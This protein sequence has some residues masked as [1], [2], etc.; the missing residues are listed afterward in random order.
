MC[1]IAGAIVYDQQQARLDSFVTAVNA[2]AS[3]GMDS[4]GVV[5]WSPASGIRRFAVLRRDDRDWLEELGRPAAG[6]PTIYLHTSRAE[7][8]TEW[9]QEKKDFDIPP[10][11]DKGIAVAHNGIIANDHTLALNYGLSRISAIDTAVLPPLIAKIGVWEA[12]AAIQGGAALAILDTHHGILTLCRNFMPL[13]LAWEPGIVYF[14]SEAGFFPDYASPFKKYQTWELPPYTGIELS[15][16][17]YRGP[18]LWGDQ[19][20]WGEGESWQSFPEL[21]WRDNG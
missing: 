17:G 9:R 5:R 16:K 4:F 19:P 8:T 20:A 3:R 6:E 2:S 15:V 11:I 21:R 7:P 14:A 13:V 18:V 10:F 1:G 12:V